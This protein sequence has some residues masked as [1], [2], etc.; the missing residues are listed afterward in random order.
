MTLRL[1]PRV[2]GPGEFAVMAIVNR[3]PDSFYDRGATFDFDSALRRVDEV[4]ADGADI[5]DIGGVRAGHG[6]DGPSRPRRSAARSTWS[7]RSRDRHPDLVVSVDTWRAGVAEAACRAGADLIN[8]AMGRCRPRRRR[9]RGPLGRRPGLQPHRRPGTAHRPASRD[10]PRRRGGRRRHDDGARREGRRGR[11]APR[12]HPGRPDS[13]LRQ[14]HAPLAGADPPP[15]RAGRNRLAGPGRAVPQGLRR[16]D[17][18]LPAA[19]RLP[20][21]LAATAVAAW[22]AR[23]FF[24]L[25]TSPRPARC[26]TW[27]PRSRA[28]RPASGLRAAASCDLG[29]R[30][31]AL[32]LRLGG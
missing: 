24:G 22:R 15:R 26:S 31:A 10:V 2:F 32:R 28:S 20:G 29:C 12:R 14:E 3:T 7:P 16:R 23:G 11:R 27:S 5:V 30:R 18:D 25:T 4:V 21:T 6:A 17:A 9:G 1:G 19:A 13:R 8:D